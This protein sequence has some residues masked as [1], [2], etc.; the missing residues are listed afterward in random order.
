MPPFENALVLSGG[1]V[2]GS[3][4]AGAIVEVL[5]S[6][7]LPTDA[8]PFRPDAIYGVSVGALNGAFLS[9]RAGRAVNPAAPGLDWPALAAELEQFWVGRITSFKVLGKKRRI[10]GL[11]IKIIRK[12]FNGLASMKRSEELMNEIFEVEN[13]R[14]SPVHYA[15]GV[16]DMRAGNYFDATI[17]KFPKNLIDYIVA[18][19]R[20]PINMNLKFISAGAGD[21]EEKPFADGGI[22][23][24]A[25]LREAIHNGAKRIVVIALK[26]K[27][28]SPMPD[29]DSV[30]DLMDLV[31]RTSGI[32]VN[33]LLNNDIDEALR[34][35]TLCKAPDNPS[36]ED[37]DFVLT[38]GPDQGKHYIPI[39]VIRPQE[40]LDIKLT[41]FDSADIA[42]MIAK[43]KEDAL[44]DVGAGPAV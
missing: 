3:Y 34:I 21:D 18:S 41:D 16:V 6:K 25:P 22:R 14:K 40:Q 27:L 8:E 12:K 4:Q 31:K 44:R 33:E 30:K 26:P 28:V 13:F 43:G 19:T 36:T 7:F 35:N 38:T 37:D 29:K 23:N 5:N 9:E 42:R 15:A 1:S 17:E 20:E 11:V 39:I 24:V 32:M 10:P 2:K